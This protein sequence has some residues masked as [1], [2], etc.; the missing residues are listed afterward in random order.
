M[1]VAIGARL[2]VNRGIYRGEYSSQ[3]EVGVDQSCGIRSTGG[4]VI[5]FIGQHHLTKYQLDP[6]DVFS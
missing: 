6:R 2:A 4:S 1:G 3:D 5:A